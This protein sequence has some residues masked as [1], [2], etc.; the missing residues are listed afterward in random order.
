MSEIYWFLFYT[1]PSSYI[2]PNE[3]RYSSHY[4]VLEGLAIQ[5]LASRSFIARGTMRIYFRH[6]WILIIICK[7]F[8]IFFNA[9]H[10]CAVG[11]L[12]GSPAESKCVWLLLLYGVLGWT[13]KAGVCG[14]G[15]FPGL[16][17]PSLVDV[18]LHE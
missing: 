14:R 16:P 15:L 2:D 11:L 10:R 7:V 1:L 6:D 9:N 4:Q 12:G 13:G 5:T 8:L 3:N 18:V 17:V